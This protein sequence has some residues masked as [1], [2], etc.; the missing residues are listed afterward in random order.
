MRT[1]DRRIHGEKSGFAFGDCVFSAKA[2]LCTRPFNL[3]PGNGKGREWRGCGEFVS[4]VGTS[5]S[6]LNTAISL[7]CF[8]VSTLVFVGME[9]RAQLDTGYGSS[10]L[11]CDTFIIGFIPCKKQQRIPRNR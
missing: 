4:G 3:E 6:G 10:Y 7:H 11:F 8:S 9:S 1:G 5:E 2:L